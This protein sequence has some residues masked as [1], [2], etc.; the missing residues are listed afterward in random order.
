MK[1]RLESTISEIKKSLER[2]PNN[3]FDLNRLKIFEN[4]LSIA[5]QRLKEA[6]KVESGLKRKLKNANEK[7]LVHQSIV[8]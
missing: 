4:R 6:K 7:Y 8:E 3:S 1:T 5:S 2:N